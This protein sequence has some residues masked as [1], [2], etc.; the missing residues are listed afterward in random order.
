MH[1][2]ALASRP[3]CLFWQLFLGWAEYLG[4]E[5]LTNL[6]A[7]LYGDVQPSKSP[8]STRRA[9]LVV[10]RQ[11]KHGI[12]K[13]GSGAGSGSFRYQQ[14]AQSSL[15]SAGAAVSTSS[16]AVQDTSRQDPAAPKLLPVSKDDTWL[17]LFIKAT[18]KLPYA[19][20]VASTDK[21]GMHLVYV[22]DAFVSL[23]GYSRA[24]ACGR[25]CRFLQ[26]GHATEE[27]RVA[28]LARSIRERR[29]CVVTITN[30]TKSGRPFANELSMHPVYDSR[31]VY[32]YMIALAC[33]AGKASPSEKAMLVALRHLMPTQFP[34]S[35]NVWEERV[36]VDKSAQEGQFLWAMVPSVVRDLLAEGVQGVSHTLSTRQS[37]VAFW[38][39]LED[40]ERE[41]LHKN[42]MDVVAMQ[43][44]VSEGSF[45]VDLK[46]LISPDVARSIHQLDRRPL[47]LFL[48]TQAGEVLAENFAAA[49]HV[50]RSEEANTFLAGYVLPT[51]VA[52]W[53][54][55]FAILAA[56]M[57]SQICL[58]DMSLPGNPLIYVNEAWCNCTGYSRE[59]VL[60]SNCRFLQGPNTEA[61]AVQTMINGMRDGVDVC[62]RVTNCSQARSS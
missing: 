23:T 13:P 20:S 49:K 44:L 5:D 1:V 27:V 29:S 55:A 47:E 35:L 34:A 30:Y 38:H 48:Q 10:G 41:L 17:T 11:A 14:Q 56:P 31:G 28:E 54:R 15:R 45:S 26:N 2:F 19:I 3:L 53:L 42:G 62:V 9:S 7:T 61:T 32:R 40:H 8:E 24:E 36:V 60:G 43:K 21:A 58:S 50:L 16:S 52:G 39:F 59:E 46:T 37:L 57:Q 22:N 6:L 18:A 4:S 51:D 33:D 25:N 12:L